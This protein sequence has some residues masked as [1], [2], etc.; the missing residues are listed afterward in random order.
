M[1][2]RA[3]IFVLYECNI[4]PNTDTVK[5]TNTDT[6]RIQLFSSVQIQ[7]QIRILDSDTNTYSNTGICSYLSRNFDITSFNLT[8]RLVVGDTVFCIR[9]NYKLHYVYLAA[10]SSIY[11][12]DNYNFKENFRRIMQEKAQI[13][14]NVSVNCSRIITSVSMLSVSQSQLITRKAC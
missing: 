7:I 9:S 13:E 6:I 2:S 11:A 4:R 3:V 12:C 10:F 14:V 1:L 5:N 8:L